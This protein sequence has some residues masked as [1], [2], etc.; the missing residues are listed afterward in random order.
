M[1][2]AKIKELAGEYQDYMVKMRR[3]FH[4]HPELSGEEFHTR[5]VLVREL[6]SMG[7]CYK[8]LPGT[9]IIAIIQGG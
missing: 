5:D 4:R 6:E 9:G 2:F 1:K 3:E 7:V 8:L